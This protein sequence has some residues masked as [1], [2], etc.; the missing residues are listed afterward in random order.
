[1]S[2]FNFKAI[3]FVSL[4]FKKVNCYFRFF[5]HGLFKLTANVWRAWAEAVKKESLVDHFLTVNAQYLITKIL[6]LSN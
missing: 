4:Y 1:V 3:N 2:A 6:K 5:V